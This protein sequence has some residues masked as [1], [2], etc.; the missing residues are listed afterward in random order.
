V[1]AKES[2]TTTI[3]PRTIGACSDRSQRWLG[4]AQM[5]GCQRSSVNLAV[6]QLRQAGFIRSRRGR[7][8]IIDRDAIAQRAC[9]CYGVL[10][11]EIDH[12][13]SA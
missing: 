5:L 10:R 11:R 3:G 13:G 9:E 6:H 8:E 7:I 1:P 12:A 2:S 4:R